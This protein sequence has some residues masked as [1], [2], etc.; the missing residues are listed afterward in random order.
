MI[1]NL[2]KK[3]K[4]SIVVII[5]LFMAKFLGFIKNIFMAKYYGTTIISDAYQMA[6]SI[7]IIIFGIALY[8]YQAFTKG[9]Y[10]SEK[11]NKG[12]DYI[13]SFITF[14]SMIILIIT[15][16][17]M[18]FPS[19]IV[20][21]FAPGFND[22]Q[23][24]Y[25]L[26]LIR[27]IIIGTAF[28]AVSNILAE[29]LRCKGS[30]IVSQ[31]SYLIINI[32]EILTIF[33]AFYFDYKWLSYGYLIA[34]FV[35]LIFLLLYCT[36]NEFKCKFYM[37]K[38]EVKKFGKILI[39]I[40]ISSIITDINS[41]IDKMFAST[42]DSGAIST[43]GYATNIRTVFLIIAAGYLTVLYPKIS[44]EIVENRYND[45]NKSINKSFL[46][47]FFM[48]A[49]I[50]MFTLFFSEQIV[51][52]VYFRGAFDDK[53]LYMTTQCL[54]MYI[55]GIVG[56]SIRDLFIKAIYCLDKG[57]FVLFI[58]VLSVIT[59]F[60]LNI[61]LSKKIGYAG[62]PLA[63]SLSV[64]LIVPIL[65]MFYKHTINKKLEGVKK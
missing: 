24:L 59:N 42:F 27:P 54:R 1:A 20:K 37:S 11:T 52:I 51:K 26:S 3:N 10:E 64:C 22:E 65:F 41:M 4:I 6:V 50:T 58:S 61:F 34:N 7:P 5:L 23:I 14:M 43:F 55:I 28:L 8:S 36:K 30:Y 17:M 12:I 9:Y 45:F 2:I 13:S 32:I 29:F 63:T 62:L 16:I 18:I 38:V 35:Y 33:L 53:S 15:L 56:I 31:L 60:V 21:I 47:L 48:Y 40:F 46:I 49:I 44:K 19:Q 25:T 39:P 57:K